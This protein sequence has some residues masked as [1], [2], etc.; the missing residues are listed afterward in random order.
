MHT[1]GSEFHI[2]YAK[3]PRV[4]QIVLKLV[5]YRCTRFIVLSEYW[6]NF[7]IQTLGLRA[8]KVVILPNAVRV[9]A[10][11]P[12]RTH[13]GIVSLVFLGRIGQRKGAFDLVKA[14]A[15]LSS[16]H[17]NKAKLTIAGDGEAFQLRSLVES[18]NLNKYISVIDWISSEQRDTLLKESD[19]FILPSYNEGLPMAL[20][21]AMSWGLPVIT[22]PV[23]G[24]PELICSKQNGLLVQPGDIEHLTAAIKFLIE[25]EEFRLILGQSARESILPL[26]VKPYCTSLMDIY[27]SILI[28][29][30]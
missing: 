27:H 18:L 5:Y 2:F 7:Y 21:E 16:E 24:I 3:L 14:F 1:H 17:L 29:G 11:I 8:E 12:Q 19:V 10:R 20:L 28:K 13:S 30:S 26:D 15:K 23:G 22:T 9:P 6:K 4:M 25:N